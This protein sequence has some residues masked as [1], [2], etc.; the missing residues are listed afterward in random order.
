MTAVSCGVGKMKTKAMI[1]VRPFV[2][3]NI[4]VGVDIV[5]ALS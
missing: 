4:R 5:K 2:A 1:L 3:V